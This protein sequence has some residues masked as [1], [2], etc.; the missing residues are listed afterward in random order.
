MCLSVVYV[1]QNADCAN[2]TYSTV[3]N[4]IYSTVPNCTY[5]T[6]LCTVYRCIIA[7]FCHHLQVLHTRTIADPLINWLIG[8]V[9][10]FLRICLGQT[11]FVYIHICKQLPAIAWLTIIFPIF[12]LIFVFVLRLSIYTLSPRGHVPLWALKPTPVLINTV[13]HTVSA[14]YNAYTAHSVCTEKVRSDLYK[15][16]NI[17]SEIH[18]ECFEGYG[19]VYLYIIKR[20]SCMPQFKPD[21][22]YVYIQLK[23]RI[24]VNHS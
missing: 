20:V 8:K 13:T 18:N 15:N 4:C 1:P 9:A 12:L 22:V 7:E 21:I 23:V 2:Y 24:Y 6:P 14:I 11:S 5:S 19:T 10:A 3:P 16:P 17:T